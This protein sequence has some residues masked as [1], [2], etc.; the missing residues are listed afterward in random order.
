MAKNEQSKPVEQAPA[1]EKI[2]RS[3][4]VREKG[5]GPLTDHQ[6]VQRRTPDLE[7]R[8]P[9]PADGRFHRVFHVQ[10]ARVS[11][12]DQSSATSDWNAPEYDSMHEANKLAVLQEAMNVGLHPRAE[13]TFDGASEPDELAGSCDLTYSV[14]CVPASSERPEEAALAYTP[15]AAL[16]DLGGTSLV[17]PGEGSDG[18]HR[19]TREDL[20][21]SQPV[22]RD[23]DRSSK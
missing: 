17:E 15:S 5:E 22:S 19:V 8:D 6:I 1:E 20:E 12:R 10:A 16:N 3:G 13:A 7:G 18:G 4:T 9:W 23:D 21:N 11:T 14:E 2:V